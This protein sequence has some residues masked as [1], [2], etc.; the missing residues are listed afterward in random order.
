MEIIDSHVHAYPDKIVLK[1]KENLEQAYS[2][3][4]VDVPSLDNLYRYM[5]NAGVSRSVLAAVATRP[6]QV[7]GINDWLFAL[8]DKRIIPFAAMHPFFEGFA[9]CLH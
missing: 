9:L 6:D 2:R 7:T 1:A 8:K 5:D 4:T 3:K